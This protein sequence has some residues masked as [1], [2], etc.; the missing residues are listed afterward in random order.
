MIRRPYKKLS[1]HY[2]LLDGTNEKSD[3]SRNFTLSPI[4]Q[5]KL[6]ALRDLNLHARKFVNTHIMQTN[7]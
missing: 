7:A 1:P 3:F 2:S 6:R 4:K 5:L